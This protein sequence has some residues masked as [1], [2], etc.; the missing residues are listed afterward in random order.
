MSN[1]N[2]YSIVLNRIWTLVAIVAIIAQYGVIAGFDHASMA[3]FAGPLV[4]AYSLNLPPYSKAHRPI[5]NLFLTLVG[6]G[7]VIS[8]GYA[9]T[10]P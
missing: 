4:I 7:N 6:L 9:P 2:S 5:A 8:G 10:S 3:L 1:T